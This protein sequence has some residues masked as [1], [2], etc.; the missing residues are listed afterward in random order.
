MKNVEFLKVEICFPHEVDHLQ[1]DLGAVILE[2]EGRS[3]ILDVVETIL[4][5]DS[6]ECKL[7]VDTE[8]FDETHTKYDLKPLDLFASDLKATIYIGEDNYDVIPESMT[9]FV[10]VNECTKAIDLKNEIDIEVETPMYQQIA[11]AKA[12]LESQGYFTGNLWCVDDVKGKFDCTDEQAQEI[13]RIAFANDATYQQ[14][15]L[16]IDYAGESIGLTLKEQN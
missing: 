10:K 3:Y 4:H 6:F 12:L 13:L 8:T 9:L 5:G 14:I 15:W 16:S 11:D 2:R 7:A 1:Y